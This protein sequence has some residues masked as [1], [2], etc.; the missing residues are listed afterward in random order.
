MKLKFLVPL[1]VLLLLGLIVF[2]DFTIYR[3]LDRFDGEGFLSLLS[4]PVYLRKYS[5]S[6]LPALLFFVFSIT[7]DGKAAAISNT[8]FTLFFAGT[9]VLFTLFFLF[10]IGLNPL[11]LATMAGII[12]LSFGII[13]IS[14]ALFE[15]QQTGVSD[16]QYRIIIEKTE[17]NDE[18]GI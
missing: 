13:K 14:S 18:Q 12:A 10:G 6:G 4:V 7:F 8:V 15:K 3:E 2:N 1:F 17:E 16:K 9:E 11:V 5:I